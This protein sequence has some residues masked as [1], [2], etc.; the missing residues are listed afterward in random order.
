M[1]NTRIELGE[2][3]RHE[4]AYW[5]EIGDV[6]GYESDVVADEHVVFNCYALAY[7]CMTTNLAVVANPGPFLY[8]N[9]GANLGV[10][11]NLAAIEVDEV[12]DFDIFPQL[13]I[14]GNDIDAFFHKNFIPFLSRRHTQ[15][16]TDYCRNKYSPQSRREE[17]F[18]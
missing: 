4:P 3:F 10:V 17:Y 13:D 9:E 16:D 1:W 7:K 6:V 12:V 2:D 18:S 14:R 11:S 8:L 15:T 5:Y